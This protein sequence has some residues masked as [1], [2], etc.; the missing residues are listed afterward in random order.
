MNAALE[1]S[2]G[3]PPYRLGLYNASVSNS[4][5]RIAAN[6]NTGT[7]GKSESETIVVTEHEDEENTEPTEAEEEAEEE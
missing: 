3:R 7:E 4:S 6:E 1:K 2:F 5:H